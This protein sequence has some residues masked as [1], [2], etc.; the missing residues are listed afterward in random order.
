MVHLCH[1]SYKADRKGIVVSQCGANNS[2]EELTL[3][4][5]VHIYVMLWQ[6][7]CEQMAKEENCDKIGPEQSG[8]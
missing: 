3:V 4:W 8:K 2:K 5:L 7:A 1:D 6:T